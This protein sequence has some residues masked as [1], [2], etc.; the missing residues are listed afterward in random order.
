MTRTRV[1][2]AA[3]VFIHAHL[4]RSRRYSYTPELMADGRRRYEQTEDRIPDIAADFGI[5]P[6]TFLRLAKREG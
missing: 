4:P 1:R 6:T 2:K 3:R 5:H